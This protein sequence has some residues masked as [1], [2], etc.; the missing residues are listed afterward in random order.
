MRRRKAGRLVPIARVALAVMIA[1]AL[2]GCGQSSQPE[3]RIP[4]QKVSSGPTIPT[5][6]LV[7]VKFYPGS[8]PT[9]GA[10]ARQGASVDL[11]TGDGA[12]KVIAFY[13]K[14]LG[15]KAETNSGLTTIEGSKNGHKLAILITTSGAATQISI[16]SE[17]P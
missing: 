17:S 13:E 8:Q 2:S 1:S 12:S 3:D 5:E 14:E 16:M 4:P 7:G 10:T 9:S 6:E 11:K 15:T